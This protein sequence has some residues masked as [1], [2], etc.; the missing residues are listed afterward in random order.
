[1]KLDAAKLERLAILAEECAEVQHMI[2]KTIRHGEDSYHP[3]EPNISNKDKLSLEVG[4]LAYAIQYCLD[5]DDL[6]EDLVSES[7]S[8][9]PTTM[10]KYLH[11]NEI[12]E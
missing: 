5:E 7:F 8:T 4:D 11:Y 1:M 2:M 12:E 9:R 10:N 3:D 6:D